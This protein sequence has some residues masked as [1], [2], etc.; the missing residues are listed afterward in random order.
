MNWVGRTVYYATRGSGIS[1]L[2]GS[3]FWVGLGVEVIEG[4]SFST[5]GGSIS[6]PN[7]ICK[8]LWGRFGNVK[9]DG[10]QRSAVSG[11]RSA[12]SGRRAEGRGQVS[13]F[14]AEGRFQED[15]VVCSGI[16]NWDPHD[17]VLNF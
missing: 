5:G 11:Q 10:C 14:G 12:V 4:Q 13:G 2:A 1:I 9:G 16:G 3:M 17:Q 15:W 7:R 8:K 6:N